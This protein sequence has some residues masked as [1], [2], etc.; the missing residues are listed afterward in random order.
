LPDTLALVI[1]WYGA[2]ATDGA[3]AECRATA[4]ALSRRGVR[5]EV[6]TTCALDRGADWIDHHAAGV[7]EEDGVTVRRFTVRA[8]D[9]HVFARYDW[10]LRRGVALAAR[11]ERE[12]VAHSIHS[13]E[14]YRYL[15][16]ERGRY[17]Y[18]FMPCGVG[19]T[20]EGAQAAP[21]RAL[22]IPRLHDDAFARLGAT[23]GVLATAR[24]VCFHAPAERA[25]AQAVVGRDPGTFAVVGRGVDT[26]APPGDPQ[27]FRDRHRLSAPF[28]LYAGPKV[29]DK[30]VP[31]LMASFAR[32][33][34]THP[35]RDVKLVLV[36]AGQL[37]I[38][39]RLCLDIVD[40]GPVEPQDRQDAFAAALALC[41]PS[42]R[43]SFSGVMMDAWL[44]GAP[45]LVDARCAV[46]REHCLRSR[47]GLFVGEYFEFVEALERLLDD[48]GLRGALA[49][50]GRAYVLAH[51]S[52]E[53]VVGNYLDVLDRLGARVA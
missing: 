34:L 40:L 19:T 50:S 16:A 48:P 28:L 15:A 8:R 20:W 22:L 25:L 11:E 27:R 21:E 49:A 30:G 45:A 17:W 5:V 39:G 29:A 31:D 24:A 52:W 53:R 23:A 2:A 46:T 37:R 18:A 38:P 7:T 33:R 42:L 36:G 32:Y 41:Q 44:A 9:R 13:D 6:L 51:F 3:V 4:R 43:E 35:D 1:P 10:R 26:D 12:L 47:G 14:L